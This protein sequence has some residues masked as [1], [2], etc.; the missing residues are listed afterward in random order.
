MKKIRIGV[1]GVGRGK[2]MIRYCEE[3]ALAEEAAALARTEE[4]K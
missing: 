2:S 4:N 3:E 1:I